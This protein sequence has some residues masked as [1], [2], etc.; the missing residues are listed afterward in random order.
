M[1]GTG[2]DTAKE[3]APGG[4]L[5]LVPQSIPSDPSAPDRHDSSSFVGST[6][7]SRPTSLRR[8][9]GTVGRPKGASST[10]V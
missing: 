6:Y 10:W 5:S 2:G 7:S 3:G 1:Y 4:M 8:R 9:P